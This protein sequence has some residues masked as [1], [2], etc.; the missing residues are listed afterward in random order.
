MTEPSYLHLRQL[1]DGETVHHT[2]AIGNNLNVDVDG[3]GWILGIERISGPVD[4]SDLLTILGATP[5]T[6][7]EPVDTANSR[8]RVGTK[9]GRT[10]YIGDQVIGM[11]DTPELAAQIVDAVNR[12]NELERQR[13]QVLALCDQA[14][15]SGN[16]S[17]WN[18]VS[19][20]AIRAVYSTTTDPMLQTTLGISPTERSP[21]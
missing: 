18:T 4:F 21:Q 2:V 13:D 19:G 10:L 5:F 16:A 7:P 20:E 15:G 12:V 17:N 8:W 9:L 11:V 1:G 6:A 3:H 14:D